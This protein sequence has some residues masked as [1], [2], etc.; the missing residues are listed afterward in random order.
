VRFVAPSNVTNA[1]RKILLSQ[2]NSFL[3]GGGAGEEAQDE[4]NEEIEEEAS[5]N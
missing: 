1:S 4:M 5:H 2:S 3:V